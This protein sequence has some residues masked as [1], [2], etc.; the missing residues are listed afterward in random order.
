MAAVVFVLVMFVSTVAEA[1]VKLPKIIG[2]DMVLQ[3]SQPVPVWGEAAAGERI[4]VTFEMQSKLT[5]ADANGKWKV[6]LDPMTASSSPHVMT[7]EG[8][9][10][11]QLKNILIGEV[12]LCSGQS[13]ME[14]S[15]RKNSKLIKTDSTKN[16]PID[17]LEHANNPAIRIFLVTQKNLLAPDTSHTGWSVARDS[18]L[19]SFSAAG[20][21][22]AKELYAKLHVPIG[23]ISAAIPGSAIEPWLP[24]TITKR[25]TDDKRKELQRDVSVPGKF[26]PKMISP[27]APFALKGFLWY[28]GETNCF[29]NEDVEYTQKMEVLIDGWRK[30]W[31]DKSL[32][33]YFVQI[34]PYY[35]SK[36]A[37]KYPLTKE[38]LPRFWEAQKLALR[39]PNTGM[40]TITD[41][42]DTAD[43]LHPPYKWEVG[44]RLAFLALAK[45]YHQNQEYSG[46]VFKQMEIHQDK[47]ELM[48]THFGQGLVSKDD[49]PLTQFIIAGFDGKFVPAEAV[50][51]GH[52]IIVSSKAVSK[53]VNVRFGWNEAGKANF[54]N[55]DGFPAVP[56]STDD[57]LH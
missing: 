51:K 31:N 42:I 26:V 9:N 48:F 25:N 57:P 4:K 44:R 35:Y 13:N 1:T 38:T 14:Y 5:T 18:A 34:A 28:Q 43:D 21:F 53:P 54:F 45:T 56:F 55:K 37:G 3:C 49:E 29:Q 46:P 30:L 7:I 33:F 41:L 22:F 50:I 15:M 52:T 23:V 16:F 20:Y 2:N 27:L 8:T 47:I 32:P 11:I 36:S 12:W 6:V 40:I 10:T 19:R 17:E 24:V 39:I